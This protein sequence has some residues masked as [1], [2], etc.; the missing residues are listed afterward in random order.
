MRLG[1]LFYTTVSSSVALLLM[2]MYVST[3]SLVEREIEQKAC[4]YRNTFDHT[5]K[6]M[7]NSTDL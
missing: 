1:S 3:C 6:R 7:N 2:M 4:F 5:R